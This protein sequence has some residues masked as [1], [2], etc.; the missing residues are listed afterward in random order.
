MGRRYLSLREAELALGRDK[1]VEYFIGSCELDGNIGIKHLSISINED[2]YFEASICETADLGDENFL[3]LGGFGP[4][5]PDIELGDADIMVNAHTFSS[6]I[7]FLESLFP[8]CST[9]LVNESLIQDE[10]YDYIK[11][12]RKM[13]EV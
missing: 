6:L 12:G 11:R 9:K 4:L 1:C 3:D 10:Y 13:I 8:G 7:N 2:E 5:N